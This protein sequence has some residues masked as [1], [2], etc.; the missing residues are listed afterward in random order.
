[1][2]RQ[3]PNKKLKRLFGLQLFLRQEVDSPPTNNSEITDTDSLI[4]R[5]TYLRFG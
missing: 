4:P 3:L 1:M 5:I 2:K